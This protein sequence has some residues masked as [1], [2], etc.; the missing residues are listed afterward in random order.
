[1]GPLR[2][3]GDTSGTCLHGGSLTAVFKRAAQSARANADCG[4]EG[5]C[6]MALIDKAAS[7]G[8]VKQRLF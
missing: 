4:G 5:S 1:M 6:E 3:S 8:D 2:A 7:Q